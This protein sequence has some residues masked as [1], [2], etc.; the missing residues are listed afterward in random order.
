MSGARTKKGT[1]TPRGDKNRP[2]TTEFEREFVADTFA[3]PPKEAASRWGRARRRP[4][5]PP[6][7]RGAQVISVTVERS[8][9][10]RSDALAE[11]MGLSRAALVARGLRA[12]LA[13]EGALDPTS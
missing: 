8:L 3:P 4:G 13:A 1:K 5:R 11:K 12:V 2:D 7:G 6:T 9:L 10:E